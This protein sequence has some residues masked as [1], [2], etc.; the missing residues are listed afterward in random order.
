[1]YVRLTSNIGVPSVRTFDRDNRVATPMATIRHRPGAGAVP[2]CPGLATG[3]VTARLAKE[4]AASPND[5]Q[6]VTVYSG[7]AIE[8][9]LPRRPAKKARMA[10]T[11]RMAL[12]AATTNRD[13]I[14]AVCMGTPLEVVGAEKTP[15]TVAGTGG[16]SASYRLGAS[17]PMTSSRTIATSG[18]AV[19][20]IRTS[21]A[22]MRLT[23]SQIVTPLTTSRILSLSFRPS[24]STAS[25][26]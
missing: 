22:E 3:S 8:S 14:A 18:G 16:S 13:A 21:F 6:M 7:S 2:A 5:S 15:G 4:M 10:R 11:M 1:M 25:P 19:I 20:P 23:S 12:T 17:C 24:I 26:P 9:T